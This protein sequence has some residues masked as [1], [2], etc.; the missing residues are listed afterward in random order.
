MRQLELAGLRF[1]LEA[2]GNESTSLPGVS[3]WSLLFVLFCLNIE[4]LESEDVSLI[5][6]TT[7]FCLYD[8]KKI[9][10]YLFTHP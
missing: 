7:I 5:P 3:F 2:S 6:Y 9:L 10:K 4:A 1:I 8:W